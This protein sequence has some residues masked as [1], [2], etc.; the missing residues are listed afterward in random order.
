MYAIIEPVDIRG[1][2][3][4]KR[5][6]YY[7]A[8]TKTNGDPIKHAPHFL[9]L[10]P[11]QVAD[12]PCILCVHGPYKARHRIDREVDTVAADDPYTDFAKRPKGWTGTKWK[13]VETITAFYSE[14]NDVEQPAEQTVLIN[15]TLKPRQLI[16]LKETPDRLDLIKKMPHRFE[17]VG[18]D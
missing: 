17:V 9:P 16:E 8:E 10:G 7:I 4:K 1:R 18:Y 12:L 13:K 3:L 6:G 5:V 14:D 11:I 15:A 2:T